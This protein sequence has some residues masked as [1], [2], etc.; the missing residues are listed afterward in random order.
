MKTLNSLKPNTAKVEIISFILLVLL[1]AALFFYWQQETKLADAAQQEKII[2]PSE[3]GVNAL[4]K[5]H[6]DTVDFPL[7]IQISAEPPA[8]SAEKPY[9]EQALINPPLP[10][11]VVK[12]QTTM[13]NANTG[14]V[15]STNRKSRIEI[16][17]R[18]FVDAKGKVVEGKVKVDYREYHDFH[19]IFLSGIPMHYENGML[20]SAGMIEI[21]ASQ[22]G[23]QVYVN[24]ENKI[25]VMLTSAY[26]SPDYNLYYLDQKEKKWKVK[27]KD[28]VVLADAEKVKT[29]K[30]P[31]VDSTEQKFTFSPRLYSIRIVCVSDMRDR[32]KNFLSKKKSPDIF[33]FRFGKTN[34][35]LPELKEF[36]GLTWR[37]KGDDA[38]QVFLDLFGWD[39][40][41]RSKFSPTDFTGWRTG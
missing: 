41:K 6:T 30:A 11:Y 22:N 35:M 34:R 27:G 9:A 20:E 28:E 26:K 21:N 38:Q 16:P 7:P 4:T 15:I 23:E 29:K 17:A 1:F 36:Y 19:D 10:V 13:V 24:P 8:L 3:H 39:E 2:P 33:D 37:Y 5:H 31:S 14:E 18:A 32:K 25:R 40:M 12:N